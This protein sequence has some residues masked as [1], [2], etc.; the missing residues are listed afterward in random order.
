MLY[1]AGVGEFRVN[2]RVLFLLL[3]LSLVFLFTEL[4]LMP[5]LGFIIEG[6]TLWGFNVVSRGLLAWIGCRT[7]LA[8]VEFSG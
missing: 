4:L 6:P 5:G 7:M 8:S 1:A 2:G 3:W